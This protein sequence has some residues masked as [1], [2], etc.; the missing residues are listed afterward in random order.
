MIAEEITPAIVAVEASGDSTPKAA[1]PPVGVME[2]ESSG[3]SAGVAES[4]KENIEV[5][6][7]RKISAI[8]KG[9]NI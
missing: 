2:V 8:E 4:A 6:R 9:C 5:G 3:P 7:K 1:A